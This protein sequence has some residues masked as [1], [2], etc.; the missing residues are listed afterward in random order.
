MDNRNKQGL[1]LKVTGS[2]NQ[3]R[4]CGEY[5]N[6]QSAFDKHRTGS[7]ENHTR[8]CHTEDEMLSKDMVRNEDGYWITELNEGY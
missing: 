2:R 8:R 6:S 7:Y 3:C 5:F 4:G 1:V